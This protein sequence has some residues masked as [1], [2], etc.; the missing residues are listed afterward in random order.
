MSTTIA[1]QRSHS[2]GHANHSGSSTCRGSGP[3]TLQVCSS[4]LAHTSP[5]QE[6]QSWQ[7]LVF[8]TTLTLGQ[9]LGSARV[10]S[11]HCRHRPCS[12]LLIPFCQHRSQQCLFRQQKNLIFLHD[13]QNNF[14][15]LVDSGATLSIL[16]HTFTE[17]STGP[18]LVG[19]NGRTILA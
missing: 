13:T 4:P 6:Q 9:P 5:S 2:S 19:A 3:P 7:R 16:P 11:P 10:G 12:P 15:F 17:P 14:R 8:S 1:V 18:H